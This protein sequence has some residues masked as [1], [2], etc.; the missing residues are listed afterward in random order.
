MSK[1]KL[2]K[3]DRAYTVGAFIVWMGDHWEID[4]FEDD[5]FYDGESVND[6]ESCEPYTGG[7]EDE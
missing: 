1:Y 5:T 4:G 6:I 7:D 2:K 3:Y